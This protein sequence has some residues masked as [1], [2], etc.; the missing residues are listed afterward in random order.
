M[1]SYNTGADKWTH[2]E[3]YYYT[4]A[5]RYTKTWYG[6]CPECGNRTTDYG[7]SII[8][9]N[10][11][12]K[13][14]SERQCVN[15]IKPEPKWWNTGVQVYKDGDQ[16]CAVKADFINLQESYAGFGDS[17]QT[18]FNELEKAAAQEAGVQK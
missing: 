10:E 4:S 15:P 5:H 2:G 16:W 6:P 1:T 13:H 14:T 8:C 12:C 7:G 17:P 9:V 18:A 11:Y 3:K